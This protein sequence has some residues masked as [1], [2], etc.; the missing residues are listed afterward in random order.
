MS[1][2]TVTL[3]RDELVKRLHRMNELLIHIQSTA[4]KDWCVN[5]ESTLQDEIKSLAESV[6][7]KLTTPWD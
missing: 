1:D 3:N 7:E 6:G 4:C 5:E 2:E